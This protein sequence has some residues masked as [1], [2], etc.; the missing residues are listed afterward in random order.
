MWVFFRYSEILTIMS[1]NFIWGLLIE[2][3]MY[4]VLIHLLIC[5]GGRE[6]KEA[7]E[8]YVQQGQAARKFSWTIAF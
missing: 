4:L 5:S 1:I 3:L 6:M 8:M 7:K 2:K